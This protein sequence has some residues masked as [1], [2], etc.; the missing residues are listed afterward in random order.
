MFSAENLDKMAEFA[1]KI[2]CFEFNGQFK[3]QIS[4]NVIGTKFPPRYACILLDETETKFLRTQ[5]F[6]PLVWFRYIDN[7]FFIWNPDKLNLINYHPNIKFN[8]E[9][10]KENITFLDLNVKFIWEQINC[11]PINY[12]LQISIKHILISISDK[13]IL[14]I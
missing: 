10:N 1:L 4:S 13:H 5:E 7:V 12:S 11:R 6:Q 14:W 8:Y 9:S 2:D 3:H